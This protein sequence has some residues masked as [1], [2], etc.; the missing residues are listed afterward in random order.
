MARAPTTSDVYNAIAEP[1][2]RQILEILSL[3]ERA[4]Q[5]LVDELRVGQ[6]TVSGHLRVLREVDLV[7]MR[8]DGRRRIYRINADALRPIRHWVDGFQHLWGEQLDRIQARAERAA[9]RRRT[10]RKGRS[11]DPAGSDT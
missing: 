1:R 10:Q 9:S 2:R 5:D 6:P 11:D 4:V 8:K 3:E 7:R